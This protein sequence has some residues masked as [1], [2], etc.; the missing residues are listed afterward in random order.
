MYL[1][2]KLDLKI[3]LLKKKS[4]FS[5]QFKQRFGNCLIN[6]SPR[7]VPTQLVL[8]AEI[9]CGCLSISPWVYGSVCP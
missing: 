7:Q 6:K 8:P 3:K 1:I 2:R 5:I 4:S 9:L